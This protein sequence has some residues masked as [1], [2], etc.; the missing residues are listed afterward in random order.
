MTCAQIIP[1]H[2]TAPV[3]V[4]VAVVV[5]AAAAAAAAQGPAVVAAAAPV[6]GYQHRLLRQ[7]QTQHKRQVLESFA[8]QIS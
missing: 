5:V 6:E 8:K 1:L 2:L 4:V 7:G 3:A